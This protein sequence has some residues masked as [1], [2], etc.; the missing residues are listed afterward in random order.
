MK[1]LE[2]AKCACEKVPTNGLSIPATH[3]ARGVMG[4]EVNE[5]I[6]LYYRGGDGLWTFSK[7]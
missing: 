2:L 4:A 6:G 1:S 7:K 3:L 5:I